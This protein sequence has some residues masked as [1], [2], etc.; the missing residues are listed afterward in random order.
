[1]K[2]VAE[3]EGEYSRGTVAVEQQVMNTIESNRRRNVVVMVVAANG[4]VND[5]IEFDWIHIVALFEAFDEGGRITGDL[6]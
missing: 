3:C 4:M 1:L 6:V 2:F 5:S